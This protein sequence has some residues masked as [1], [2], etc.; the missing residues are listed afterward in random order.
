MEYVGER[1][2]SRCPVPI[3]NVIMSA[4]GW[5]LRRERFGQ[6]FDRASEL[7]DRSQ[8]L[9]LEELEAYQEERLRL[10]VRHAYETVPYYRD[11]MSGL[12]LVPGD[13]TRLSDL[14]KLP[15]LT[16]ADVD[17]SIEQLVSDA[18][19]RKSLKKTHSAGTTGSSLYMYWDREI[20]YMNNACLWR[21]RNWA[22]VEFGEPIATC[23]GRPVVPLD[24][25]GP[26]YW[27]HNRPWNYLMLSPLH[28]TDESAPLYIEAMR[29]VGVVALDA[30]PT[31]AY[32]LARFMEERDVYLPLRCVFTT[33]EPL[34][35]VEREVI[36][37]RF[38]CR[39]FDGYSQ[40]ERVMYSSECDRHTGHHLYMEF[41][42]TEL[43]DD[44]GDPV[45][46]GTVG[47]VVATGLHNFGM[48]LIRYE[49]GDTASMAGTDCPC[50]RKLPLM[51]DVAMR[52]EDILVTPDGRLVPPLMVARAFK[53][54]PGIV[55]SQIVQHDPAEIT[56]RLVVKQPLAAH[57]EDDLRRNIAER[58]GPDVRVAIE[59]VDDIPLVGRGK[60]RRVISTVPLVW[61]KTTTANLYQ[62]GGGGEVGVEST[63]ESEEERAGASRASS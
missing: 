34:L 55:R 33:S 56:T 41:G 25:K 11:L 32:V 47:R 26:P 52:A 40:S 58:L 16:R 61:G 57:D 53:L 8:W 12:K 17:R 37:E 20:G 24:Q 29:E 14:P 38:Q 5:K 30:H 18:A 3:Q 2:Y 63:E 15:V 60:Y 27:R 51:R 45:P 7:L 43:L 31:A 42:I 1:L 28:M 22:G 13:I 10:V 50:G 9:S 35:D 49:V 4:Y 23:L 62:E 21:E 44:D 46:D 6:G 48:P 59:Y 39:V 54:L 36:E 19:P